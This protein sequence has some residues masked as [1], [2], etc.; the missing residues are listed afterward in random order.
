MG[1]YACLARKVV[2]QAAIS[3]CKGFSP[4]ARSKQQLADGL[5]LVD[6]WQGE[7][8]IC[9]PGGGITCPPDRVP[10]TPAEGWPP[11]A[12]PLLMITLQTD[13]VSDS[14]IL[15]FQKNADHN[16]QHENNGS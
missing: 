16:H 5:S 1:S 9:K 2:E 7:Q 12:L 15:T 6:Q 14:H 11:S 10:Q 13:F 4:G 8:G 3:R